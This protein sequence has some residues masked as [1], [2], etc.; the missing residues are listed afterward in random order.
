MK[1]A[2]IEVTTKAE[3]SPIVIRWIMSSLPRRSNFQKSFD[4][5]TIDRPVHFAWSITARII[6]I[7]RIKRTIDSIYI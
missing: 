6:M 5:G 7:E 2:M 1:Y 4:P 3:I